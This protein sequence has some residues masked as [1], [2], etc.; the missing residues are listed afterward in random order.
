[1]QQFFFDRFFERSL[2]RLAGRFQGF[3]AARKAP[4]RPLSLPR[5]AE[6]GPCRPL[7]QAEAVQGGAKDATGGPHEALRA[8]KMTLERFR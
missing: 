4:N 8:A 6:A 2:D 3:V 1:M 5:A 7:V